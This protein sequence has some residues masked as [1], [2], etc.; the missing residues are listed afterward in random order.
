MNKMIYVTTL[1]LLLASPVYAQ[2]ASPPSTAVQG[3]SATLAVTAASARVA[4]PSSITTYPVVF[5]INNGTKDAFVKL[6]TSSV[7]AATTD[8]AIP[9]G[10][11]MALVASGTVTNIAAICG[12]SDSTSLYI[13]AWTGRPYYR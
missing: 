11:A 1:I 3:A 12:G 6:G 10:H 13:S 9:A 7:T 2:V 8:L 5:V 4:L